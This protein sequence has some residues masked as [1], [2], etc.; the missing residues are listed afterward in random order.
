MARSFIPDGIDDWSLLMAF[1]NRLWYDKYRPASFAEYVW[2]DERLKELVLV[3]IEKKSIPSI[4]LAGGPGRGKSTLANLLIQA[5]GIAESDVLRLRGSKDNNAETIRTRVQEFCE[6]G[7]WSD[8]RIIYLDEADLLSRKAQEMLRDIIDDYADSVRF[9]FT[10]NYP[11]K[12]IEE[13]SQSRL[14]RIDIDKLPEDEFI[15]RIAEVLVAEGVELD[16][17]ALDAITEIKDG[18]YP[19]LRKALN[20]LE[21]SV[22]DGKL[23]NVTPIKSAVGAWE[24][25]F[26]ALMTEHHDVLREICKIRETLAA[27]APDEMEEVYRFFY[28]N[29]ARLF[30]D[31]QIKAIYIINSGQKA[32]RNALLP[33]MILLEVIIRLMLL[34]NGQE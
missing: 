5:L 31:K 18:C 17:P 30:A 25:Y 6:L 9:I 22:R 3:W 20:L 11:H 15:G 21:N 4:M 2:S 28:H 14:F 32:H 27:L 10:C 24:S 19:D 12:I 16:D 34:S 33:D 7:G 29:G 1:E 26:T 23:K 13:V 8:L